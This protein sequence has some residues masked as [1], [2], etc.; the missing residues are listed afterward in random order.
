MPPVPIRVD[1]GDY[2]KV[3]ET[4]GDISFPFSVRGD[5][6][7]FEIPVK[8]N[9]D[10]RSFRREAIGT[11]RNFPQG[12][13]YL[14]EHGNCADDGNGCYD[15]TK[16]YASVPK[17]RVEGETVTWNLR[18]VNTVGS[19][20]IES[21]LSAIATAD[22][23]YEYFNNSKPD[24]IIAPRFYYIGNFMELKQVVVQDSEVGLYKGKIYYRK[25]YYANTAGIIVFLRSIQ[26]PIFPE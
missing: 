9:V 8:C 6:E 23:V 2:S 12:Y 17:R 20:G 26:I 24:P 18:L 10:K 14:V 25:T 4:A 11:R 3:L 16:T 7:S 13:A 15:Y 22:V 21:N 5:G 19:A 1:D